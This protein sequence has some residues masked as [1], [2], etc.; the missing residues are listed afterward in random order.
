MF[1]RVPSISFIAV[2]ATA[3]IFLLVVLFASSLSSP[4]TAHADHSGRPTVSIKSIMPEVGEEGRNVTVTLKL[5]RPLTDDEEWC[6][7]GTGPDQTPNPGKCIE[8]GLKIR[9]NY[10]DH[11]NEEGRNPP[12]IDWRFVFRGTQVEDR[13]TVDIFDDECITP[14]RQLEIWIDTAYQ[15]RDGHPDENKY[16]YDIDTTSHF[17]RIIGNDDEDD[18]ATLWETFDSTKHDSDST[19]TCASVEE[20]AKEAGDY[21]RMPLFGDSDET[22]SVDENTASGE[23]IGDPITANDPDGDALTYTLTGTDA[24]S[25]SID[26]ST[27]QI[28]TRDPLD[29]ETMDTYH[30]AVSVRDGK[31]IDGNSDTVEDDS[32]GVTINVDDVAEPPNPPGTPT[33]VPKA[34][35]PDSLEVSWT[36]PDTTGRPDITGYELQY[37]VEGTDPVDWIPETV[38]D[39]GNTATITGLESGTTYEVQVR[40]SN[41]EGD[42][43]WSSSGEGRTENTVPTFDEE[44]PQGQNSLSRSVPENSGAGVN[45]GPPVVAFDDDSDELTYTLDGTDAASFT[46]VSTSGQIQ[47]KEG[48]TYDHESK[49]SY[50]VT[51]KA[52]DGKSGTATIAVTIT[53]T[54]VDE[55]GTLSFS[56][57]QPIAG[58]TLE[59]TLTDQD[60]VQ[61]IDTWQW[62]I[63]TDRSTWTEIT[64]AATSSIVPGSGDIGKYLRVTVEYTQTDSSSKTVEGEAGEV[65]TAPPT[66][67]HP[68]FAD[69]TATRSVAENTVA[70]EPIGDP[71]AATHSDS[72]G[73]LS[74][75]LDTTGADTFDIDTA[76]GQLKTKAALDYETDATSY[77]VTV[78]VT[79]GLDD[80][81]HTD[82]VVD[83]SIT[84]TI[85]VTDVNEP[86]Q[87]DPN[88]ATTLELSEDITSGTDV[89]NRYEA[90]DPEN[91]ALTY[92]VSGTDAALFEVDSNGQ[93]RVAQALD[94]ETKPT[95]TVIVQVSDSEDTAGNTET[96]PGT[97]DDSITVTITVTNIFEAPRF[98]DEIPQGESSVTRS[99]PE[100][101]S[102]DQPVGLPVAATDDERDTLTYSITGTDAASFEFET[103]TGQIKTK[104][105]LNHETREFYSVIVEVTDGKAADG[106]T[107]ETTIDTTIVVTIEVEDINEKP[108]FDPNAVTDLS[109]AENTAAD[110]PIGAAF[111]ASD[112]DENEALTYG[113]TGTDAASFDIDTATGQIKTKA[114]L[115]HEIKAT[116][117]LTVTVSDGRDGNG[118]A[119]TATD[120]ELAVT[121][122]VTDE[123]DP[124]TITLSSQQPSAGTPLTATLED[125]DGGI[126]DEVWKW[127]ISDAQSQWTTI[128]DATTNTYI[129]GTDDVDDYLRVSVTYTDNDGSNKT[130]QA[131]PSSAVLPTDPTNELPAFD[132]DSD[133]A[134][135]TVR[136]N[137]PAGQSIGDPFTA[138]DD[139]TSDTL[140]Y[141]LS[142]TDAASFAIV[143]TTG[144]IQTKEILDYENSDSKTSYTVTAEVHDGKDPW[145]NADTSPD[146]TIAVT[147]NVT[148]MLVPA[149]PEEP[150]VDPTP[151]AAAGLTV[152]WTA[153]ADTET[154]PVVGYDV[155]YRVKDT[156][157]T[158][159][160]L[161]ANVTVT[162]TTATITIL[163]YSTTYEVQ[164][165][166]R[167][168]EGS[169][170]WSPTREGTIP[171][172]LDVTFSPA[173]RR[174]NEGSSASYTV[175]VAPAT[176]RALSI[177]VTISRG[178]AESGDYSPSSTTLTF[179]SSDTS[180]SFTISTTNDSDRSDETLSIR[181]GQLPAAVGT[182]TQATASLTINDTTPAPRSNT[183][184]NTGGGGGGGGGGS[185]GGSSGGGGGGGGG[186]YSSYSNRGRSSSPVYFAPPS[187]RAPSFYEGDSTHRSIAENS[188]SSVP[189]G[190]PI[191]ATDPE[192]DTL[193]YLLGGLDGA[194]FSINPNTG[195]LLTSSVL[196]FEVQSSY[197]VYIL[198]SDGQGGS[199]R[200]DVSIFV[201]D[202]D[203]TPA[204][205]PV[206]QLAVPTPEPTPV[207][208]PTEVPTPEP[209]EMPT[210]EPTAVPTPTA[211]PTAVPTPTLAPTPT[212]IPTPTLAPTPTAQPTPTATPEPQ[213]ELPG[214]SY[215][216]KVQPPEIVDLGNANGASDAQVVMTVIPEDLRKFRIWPIILLVLGAIMELAALSMFLKEREA[217]K[218]K[219]WSPY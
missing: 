122:T 36:T 63:S 106:T 127:E 167:N 2:A 54:D 165:A 52:D 11:L 194:S 99:V 176:D 211:I 93:L 97:I 4:G 159:P 9:D 142:G 160:W 111:T 141:S 149:I 103:A 80:Y 3:L 120:A 94:F 67:Q 31:D 199:N 104:D 72:V 215:Q 48:V 110:T 61:S 145:G 98:D 74:Y 42:S 68:T 218:R 136:E 114:D 156:T 189:I 210:P 163:E 155:Q 21:N 204:P 59:A 138:T 78:S 181:F 170:V 143:D 139:D 190:S 172:R 84:V 216:P 29:H 113:L 195:Q 121:I 144:Q 177:P 140:T 16:G 119:D 37:Q 55:E 132:L 212:A 8:G 6:Y 32:I 73:T 44:I 130:V 188:G 38:T 203:E 5:S 153:I 105:A 56:P 185:K 25:F 28:S 207:P 47:T 92:S 169:S 46:I 112:E 66:N 88:A 128:T 108:T 126:T 137:T 214:A 180:K 147:I 173:S 166:S 76:T 209:T 117:T 51:V 86:P 24:A 60:G 102:A 79:D 64:G 89:G 154:A 213:P 23:A 82:S 10:N 1:H 96:P 157:D 193:T 200:I 75:S 133:T 45:V 197:S 187:N 43:D 201:V 116:Y 151:G 85:D 152:T 171:S 174:I 22:I 198:V 134:T 13:I 219:F 206:A 17:V 178:T 129:P 81:S 168:A 183:N 124:G 53:V 192:N 196:D 101:T 77:T 40:A 65:L 118:D 69:Q 150:D 41:D 100:N 20:G 135:L 35:A 205:V 19:N 184:T 164:V 58:T 123:D 30:L 146:D 57:E 109:I 162:G 14:D 27:G 191:S 15:D 175:T 182:G 115:D 83:D 217:D 186:G 95:L 208:P 125:Q 34:N 26:S 39:T 33:V 7:P 70:G 62:E 90:T 87:F 91:D 107:A 18:P 131:Q 179:A 71:V 49:S 202:V 161:D 158:D 50:S 148:D 12:D